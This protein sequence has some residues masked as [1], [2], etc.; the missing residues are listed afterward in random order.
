VRLIIFRDTSRS[1]FCQF[2]GSSFHLYINHDISR[3]ARLPVL[4][5]LLFTLKSIYTKKKKGYL[6]RIGN[7]RGS[8]SAYYR[9]V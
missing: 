8:S 5:K 9:G 7:M 6:D 1:S 3:P 2:G 4:P